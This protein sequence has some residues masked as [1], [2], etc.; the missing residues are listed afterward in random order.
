MVKKDWDKFAPY[1][2]PSWERKIR[3]FIESDNCGEIYDELT[4]L[5]AR[6]KKLL[7]HYTQTYRA[8]LETNMDEIKVMLCG[9][10]PYH[11]LHKNKIIA[12]GI[13]MSCSNTM[14]LAPSLEHFYEGMEKELFPDS[15]TGIICNPDLS[16]LCHQGVF[17][18]NASMT[19]E[20]G[21]AGAHIKLWEPFTKYILEEVITGISCPIIWLGKEAEKL[22]RWVNP[23][24]WRFQVEHPAAASHN[25]GTWNSDGCFKKVNRVLKDYNNFELT[26]AEE[27]PF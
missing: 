4:K 18:F 6:G 8:F 15:E 27:L 7:P 26:W 22:D 13:L 1:F 2:H 9:M 23:F 24:Q 10:S 5:R 25:G 11:T 20:L 21:K 3:P 14:H 16:Y 17:M 12:D 19:T